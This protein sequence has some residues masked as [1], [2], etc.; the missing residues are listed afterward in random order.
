[1]L[2]SSRLKA[3]ALQVLIALILLNLSAVGAAEIYRWVDENGKVHFSDQKPLNTT[4]SSELSSIELG[5]SESARFEALQG[6]VGRIVLKQVAHGQYQQYI[7]KEGLILK[8][9]KI[10]VVNHGMFGKSENELISAKN[11]LDDW[12]PFSEKHQ[13][14]IVA[15]AYDNANYAV[16]ERGDGK[17]GYRGLFGRKVGA[18]EFLH[19][20][21]LEYQRAKTTY[22]GRFYLS[23]HSAGAQFA[24]RYLVRH[25]ERVIAAAF[26][27]PA[28]YAQPT[29]SFKWPY[30]MGRRQFNS[31]WPGENISRKIDIQP[32]KSDWL[33]AA[34]K[35]VAVV[36]GELD[37]DKLRY[38]EG[39]GGDTH[40]GRAKHWVNAMNQYAQRFGKQGRVEL[41]LIPA[42]GHNY[43]KLAR[44]CQKFLEQY[45]Q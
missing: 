38:V 41:K 17:G 6:E 5:L 33:A 15:P 4:K 12:I 22:D 13:A 19:E 28:W 26:S 35:P 24:N 36:V 16:T 18:D 10:V 25:P 31:R 43:G 39:I 40:V 23:G 37:L 32:N 27:A 42:V 3:I 11:T 29:E 1:M 30:G 2:L 20:I 21:I 34:Q 7:P 45:M 44:Q 8:T 14:I 9:L